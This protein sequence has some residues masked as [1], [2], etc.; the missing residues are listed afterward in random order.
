MSIFNTQYAKLNFSYDKE[1]VIEEILQHRFIEIPAIKK[2]LGL[3]PFDIVEKSLYDKVTVLTEHG[4]IL[5]S[6]PSWKGYSFTH[7]PG[8]MM[9]SYG[10]NLSRIKHENW[11]WK[12]DTNSPY[13]KQLVSDLGFI[14]T[15]N[16]RAMVLDPPGFG[17][18][19]NDVPPESNYY[20]NHISVT[21]NI[22]NGGQPLT[23]MINNSLVEI[24]DDCFIF[25]DDCWHGVNSVASQR[26][27]LRINGIVD[28]N[29]IN[30]ILSRN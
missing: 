25:R 1:K 17:P 12:D 21:L 11:E 27:Q 3:R 9:S 15:Q 18:V 19:H 14:S 7:V 26:I 29:R 22:K 13:I 20:K 16:V 5:G 24:D 23:A 8:D 4:I 30:E 28:E 6:I 10:G 2:F